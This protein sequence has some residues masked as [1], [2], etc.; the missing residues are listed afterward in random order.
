MANKYWEA[1]EQASLTADDVDADWAGD[2]S[3]LALCNRAFCLYYRT[4]RNAREMETSDPSQSAKIQ[5]EL[6]DAGRSGFGTGGNDDLFEAFQH[7]DANGGR[8]TYSYTEPYMGAQ[9]TPLHGMV[10]EVPKSVKNFLDAVDSRMDALA[11]AASRF[12]TNSDR[13]HRAVKKGEWKTVGRSLNTIGDVSGKVDRY[14]WLA[15]PTKT[16]VRISDAAGK[17]SKYA[18]VVGAIYDG[19]DTAVEMRRHVAPE[20]ALAVGALRTAVSFVPVAGSMLSSAVGAA[21]D[22]IQAFKNFD[23]AMDRYHRDRL[24]PVRAARRKRGTS[25]LEKCDR[26]RCEMQEPCA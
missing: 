1:R 10:H 3:A 5:Q 16:V 24:Y 6:R 22:A 7:L 21:P 20:E 25:G 23:S 14:L 8:M 9:Q 17:I 2:A 15:P 11:P 19:A 4:M 18:D 13:L 12:K 26:C